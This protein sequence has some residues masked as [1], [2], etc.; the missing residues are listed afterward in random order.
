MDVRIG[1]AALDAQAAQVDVRI[2]WAEFDA[3]ADA[4]DVRIGWAQFDVA[5]APFA[6]CV[7]WAELDAR[8]PTADPVPPYGAGGGVSRYHSYA[9]NQYD[10]PVDV[11]PD[12]EEQIIVTIMMEIAAHALV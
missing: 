2:G 12:E 10:I 7:G 11:D 1:W 9:Q 4:M 3:Q 8:S 5:A 6:V